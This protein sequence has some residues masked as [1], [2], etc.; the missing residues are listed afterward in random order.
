M[1][2]DDTKVYIS[3]KLKTPYEAE[4]IFNE[5]ISDLR[6]WMINHKLKINDSKT[7]FL[8]IRSQFSKVTLS[9]LTVTVGDTE[10]LSSDKAR[11]LGVIFDSFM[12][13]EPIITQVCRVAYMHLSNVRKIRKMLTDEG[14][15]QLIHGFITSRIDY[16]NS[17]L[18]GMADT[19]LSHL[20]R[21]QNT[22][23][24]IFTKCGDRNYPSIN[25]LKKIHWLPV[26]QRITYKI[27]ILTFKAYH[28]TAAQH[29]LCDL[30]IPRPYNSAVRSNNSFALVVPMIKLKHYGE[31]SFSYAAPVEWNKLDFEIRSLNNLE[32][33]KKKVKTY[34][35]NTAFT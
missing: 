18:Y 16:S 26:R 8:I 25:L 13:L 30:I 10:I 6:T 17:I 34:V 28:K 5:C 9:N 21:I 31:R 1:Y 29:I 15:S 33:F 27:F 11:N 22:A 35:F 2:A 4:D 14:A 3:F 12:N 19:I 20:Q 7:E 32:T 24:R 23:A